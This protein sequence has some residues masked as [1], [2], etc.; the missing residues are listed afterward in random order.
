MQRRS[1]RNGT[2]SGVRQSGA[3]GGA[4]EMRRLGASLDRG[5]VVRLVDGVPIAGLDQWRAERIAVIKPPPVRLTVFAHYIRCGT[6]SR[7]ECAELCIERQVTEG[8]IEMT[9]KQKTRGREETAREPYT[10]ML[11]K[12]KD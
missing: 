3:G 11:S 8:E 10:Q 6:T 12:G 1:K 4:L 7:V 5:M 9:A 2:T